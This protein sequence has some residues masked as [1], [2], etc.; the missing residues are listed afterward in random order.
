MNTSRGRWWALGALALAMLTIG[1]DGTVLSVATPTMAGSLH[2]SIDQLQWFSTAYTLVLAGVLL[3]AGMLGDRFGRKRFLLAA[4]ALFGAAS[5]WSAYATSPGE[6]IAARSLLGLGAAFLMPLSMAVLPVLFPDPGE[7]SRA[8]MIWV[9]STAIGLPLGPILGGYLLGH[10]WW[11]SVFLIN[12]PLV[13]VGLVA[14]AV[15]VPESRSEQRRRPDLLGVLL[16][17][18]GLTGL[19]Y[20]FIAAGQHGWGAT[21]AWLPIAVGVVLLVWFVLWQRRT[22]HALVELSL[23]GNADFRQGLLLSLLVN[24]S[25]MGLFF[26]LPQYFQEVLGADTLGTGLRLL[27][28][29]G[30]LL[31]GTRLAAKAERRAER[32]IAGPQRGTSAGP[33]RAIGTA[34]AV[35]NRVILVGGF[36]VLAASAAAGA[37]TSPTDGYGWCAIWLSALGIGLGLVMPT[38]M[39]IAT[40]TLSAERSGAGSALLQA[41]RQAAGTIGVA[42]LGTLLSATYRHALPADLPAGVLQAAQRNVSTGVA[43]AR[44]VSAPAVESVRAAFVHGQ[45][46]MLLVGAGIALIGVIVA[47]RYRPAA[48]DVPRELA[49]AASEG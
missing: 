35:G 38:A 23:F 33:R 47:L 18:A 40:G 16:S 36:G 9:T 8:I 41:V 1:L 5:A 22:D 25:M 7:R 48:P 17:G 49:P 32:S 11:G 45:N 34:S 27:P 31:V 6:L 3:P 37:F 28:M 26:V 39:A 20:G 29:I 15:L 46:V 13:V 2:A 30:G 21:A 4:L 43:A 14:V 44:E 12:L 24:F 42:V 10:F 19:T